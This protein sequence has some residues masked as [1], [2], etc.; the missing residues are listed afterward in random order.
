MSIL[1]IICISIIGGVSGM[2][3]SPVGT[4]WGNYIL[5]RPLIAS[6][7]IGL[8]IG[9]VPG[10]VMLGIPVQLTWILMVTPGGV[11]RTDLRSA[12][13]AGLAVGYVAVRYSGYAYAVPAVLIAA[14]VCG[15]FG[16]RLTAL[17]TKINGYFERKALDALDAGHT[18]QLA[19][20]VQAGPLLS[21]IV[22]SG[23]LLCVSIFVLSRLYGAFLGMVSSSEVLTEAVRSIGLIVP[24]WGCAQMVRSST[25]NR[26]G[27]LLSAGGM[28]L[29]YF[30]LPV[31]AA[32]V[33]S[34]VLAVLLTLRIKEDTMEEE[35]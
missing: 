18:E 1:Q 19:Y 3:A 16:T 11:M 27:Y 10:M 31:S 4:S 13:Y 32:A 8:I 17:E 2:V 24:L 20:T 12:S 22:V 33:C 34:C 28:V 35:I 30:G 6:L 21:H 14:V 15:F 26:L 9:D 29:G 7:V 25:E 23:S 5:G